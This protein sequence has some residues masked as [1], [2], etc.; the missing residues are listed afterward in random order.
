LH[1]RE[2]KSTLEVAA[3]VSWASGHHSAHRPTAAGPARRRPRS[4]PPLTS[5]LTALILPL[6]AL[7]LAQ[8]QTS[9]R[10][11]P[12]ALSFHRRPTDPDS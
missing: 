12:S 8:T 5:S 2:S 11:F 4:Q 6:P 1:Y 7:H 9:S 3:Q 10:T